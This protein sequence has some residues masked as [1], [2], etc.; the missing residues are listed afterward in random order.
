ML[1]DSRIRKDWQFCTDILPQVSRT[2]ALNIRVLSRELRHATAAAYLLCRILDTV[3]DAAKF[4]VERKSALLLE[5][6]ALIRSGFTD[7]LGLERW[8]EACKAVDGKAADLRLLQGTA[9]VVRCLRS[10]RQPLREAIYASCATMAVGMADFCLRPTEARLT[11]VRDEA[12]LDAYCYIVAGT[13]GEMLT[14]LFQA[15]YPGIPQASL[16]IMHQTAVSFGLALQITNITK[17]FIQDSKRGT[18]FIPETILQEAGLDAAAFAGQPPPE[19]IA[20]V[21]R[22]M[23]IKATGHLDDAMTYTL[24]IPRRYWR[25]RLFCLWP[26]MMAVATLQVVCRDTEK[27]AGGESV[28]IGRDWVKRIIYRS[29]SRV[30]SNRLLEGDYRAVRREVERFAL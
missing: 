29:S 10:L 30:L 2:F 17:D 23:A 3:E 1:I 13:V 4:P 19:A 14:A 20:R 27:L 16:Q 28:K 25:A 15:G 24:A 26:L 9:R 8:V 22:R 11:P 6:A 5:G 18:C 7:D 12:D 21:V